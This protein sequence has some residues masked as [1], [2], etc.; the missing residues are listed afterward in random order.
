[1]LVAFLLFY[2]VN[3][4]ARFYTARFFH[5]VIL[6]FTAY[7]KLRPI[8]S[9]LSSPHNPRR[10]PIDHPRHNSREHPHQAESEKEQ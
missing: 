7:L 2:H 5:Q 10:K 4:P 8:L 6:R 9:L 3:I 1:M